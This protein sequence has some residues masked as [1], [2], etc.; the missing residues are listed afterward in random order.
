MRNRQVAKIISVFRLWGRRSARRPGQQLDKKPLEDSNK[1]R[2]RTTA[3]LDQQLQGLVKICSILDSCNLCWF[4]SGGTLLGAVREGAFIPWDWDVEVTVLTEQALGSSP[5]LVRALVKHG[6][7]ITKTDFSRSN[8][9]IVA[10]GFGA[11]YEIHGLRMKG[12]TIRARHMMEVSASLFESHEIVTLEGRAFPGPSPAISY[13]E[14]VY[15]DWQTPKRTAIK[16]DYLM[17][18]ANLQAGV[19]LRIFRHLNSAFALRKIRCAS[20]LPKRFKAN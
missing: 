2:T 5:Q 17:P 15:G 10:N 6:F 18:R 8:L 13:L 7:E 4:L 20:D 12:K 9:K 11:K 14:Q 16:S 3:E 1:T 19:L